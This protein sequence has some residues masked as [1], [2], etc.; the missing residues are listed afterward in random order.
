MK[1]ILIGCEESQIVCGAFRDVG[2]EAYSCDLKE[3]RGNSAWHYQQCIMEVIP[4]RRWDLIILH[5]DCT[6]MAVC[7][8]RRCAKGKPQYENRIKDIIWTVALWELAK[9]YSSRVA[10]ENPASTIFPVLRKLGAYVQYIQPW[11]YG[12]GETKKTGFALH[13]LEPLRPT[14]I[15]GGREQRIWK[16]PPSRTRKRDR[17][18]TYL[19]V[20][21][22]MVHQ[23]GF[24]I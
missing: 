15:V 16:M 11:E 7:N 10:L 12:H 24:A 18:E 5:P 19:G 13:G 8:N 2:F 17:S 4:S 14:N 21:S 6:Y 3:T 9:Q 22:A 1:H 23:W 20:G